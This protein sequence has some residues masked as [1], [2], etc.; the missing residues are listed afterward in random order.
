M[1]ADELRLSF[2]GFSLFG[3]VELA[4]C[5][6]DLL[7]SGVASPGAGGSAAVLLS[8]LLPRFASM[9]GNKPFC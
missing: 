6:E 2:R 7:D 5:S 4:S 9:V 3:A 1:P 8:E